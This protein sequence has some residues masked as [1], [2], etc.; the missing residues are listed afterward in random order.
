MKNKDFTFVL[1]NYNI[2]IYIKPFYILHDEENIG[3]FRNTEEF[4]ENITLFNAG[5]NYFSPIT[6]GKKYSG[7]VTP[8]EC[9]YCEHFYGV[10]KR[11]L[12]NGTTI[13]FVKCGEYPKTTLIDFIN[14]IHN[15]L[16]KILEEITKIIE[17]L[18]SE[19]KNI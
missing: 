15:K 7:S 18:K 6:C 17:H 14:Y 2:P 10:G 16:Q 4:I 5:V 11:K 3:N 12:K 19:I 13:Y 8:P 9:I 1:Q